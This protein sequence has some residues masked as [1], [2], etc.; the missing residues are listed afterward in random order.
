MQFNVIP[1]CAYRLGL[2]ENLY[3]VLRAHNYN[4]DSCIYCSVPGKPV[5]VY[6][7]VTRGYSP[8]VGATVT[9]TLHGSGGSQDIQLLDSGAGADTS[10]NDGIYSGY[11]TNAGSLGKHTISVNVVGGSQ[12]HVRVTRVGNK[13]AVITGRY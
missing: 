5:A 9:A 12:T 8:V 4:A 11:I 3:L 2:I 7:T 10:R 13:A 6:A 1:A